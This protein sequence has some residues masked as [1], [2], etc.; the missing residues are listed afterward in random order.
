MGILPKESRFVLEEEGNNNK[1]TAEG[2]EGN[3]EGVWMDGEEYPPSE[4]RYNG[5]G[6]KIRCMNWEH[7][8]DS[9]EVNNRNISKVRRKIRNTISQSKKKDKPINLS[10]T[11]HP[12][13]RA[14]NLRHKSGVHSQPGAN[15]RK[16]RESS[17]LAAAVHPTPKRDS[18]PRH[19]WENRSTTAFSDDQRRLIDDLTGPDGAIDG[20]LRGLVFPILRAR[21]HL[22]ANILL[23]YAQV[24]CPV[25]VGHG[26]TPYEMEAAVTKGFHSSTLEDYAI[27]Q[28]RVEAQEKAAQG[29][30]PIVRW[31]NIKTEPTQREKR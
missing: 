21:R 15:R 2:V 26:W 5:E 29:F 31:D 1:T 6:K 9:F 16:K 24:G 8:E 23:K 4:I 3:N 22:A 10:R 20:K 25:S 11:D 18:V 7:V 17:V 13:F 19:W 27:S 12:Q 30:A 14:L 28:I